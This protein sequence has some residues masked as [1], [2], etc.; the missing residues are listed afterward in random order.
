M[1]E[2]TLEKNEIILGGW[3]AFRAV[4]SEDVAIFNKATEHLLGVDYTPLEVSTQVV[5]GMNYRFICESKVV[6][7]GTESHKATVTIYQPLKGDPIVTNISIEYAP[8]NNMQYMAGGWSQWKLV[9]EESKNVFNEAMQGFVGVKYTPLE[10][11]SQVVA[12]MNYKYRCNA[13]L[14]APGTKPYIAL[15]EIFRG[16]PQDA[17][18]QTPV[19]TDIQRIS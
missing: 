7:P 4:D 12:G 18:E 5:A 10:V 11:S 16:L 2:A 1:S 15:V 17:T 8:V 9:D 3:S 6:A 14:V 19:I 13:Q